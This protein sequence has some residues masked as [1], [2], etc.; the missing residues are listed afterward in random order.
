MGAEV[1]AATAVVAFGLDPPHDVVVVGVLVVGVVVAT[2]T[3][4]VVVVVGVVKVTVT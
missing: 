3:V 1:V 2:V 4:V